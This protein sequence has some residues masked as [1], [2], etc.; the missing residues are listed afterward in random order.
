[1]TGYTGESPFT[2]TTNNNYKATQFDVK[3]I[4]AG[5]SGMLTTNYG[6]WTS[7]EQSATSAWVLNFQTGYLT[8]GGKASSFNVRAVLAF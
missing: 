8:Y 4:A 3:I 1:M 5:G 6:C 2:P 7:T